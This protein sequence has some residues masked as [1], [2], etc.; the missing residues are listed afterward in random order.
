ML[1]D[2]FPEPVRNQRSYHFLQDYFEMSFLELIAMPP[3]GAVITKSAFLETIKHV[4]TRLTG[5]TDMLAE[6]LMQADS[7]SGGGG[8]RQAIEEIQPVLNR[9]FRRNLAAEVLV[10]LYMDAA[11][12]DCDIDGQAAAA[13][14]AHRQPFI[15]PKHEVEMTIQQGRGT[16]S[17]WISAHLAFCLNEKKIKFLGSFFS[18]KRC[19]LPAAAEPQ[20]TRMRDICVSSTTS[21]PRN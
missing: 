18:L 14:K 6:A 1:P 7:C 12:K 16:E 8:D 13:K 5:T 20:P 9:L 21:V 15:D 19:F 10:G 17:K 3:G 2:A 11:A 4:G